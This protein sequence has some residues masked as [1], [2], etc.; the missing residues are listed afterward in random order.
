M[1]DAWSFRA[2]SEIDQRGAFESK[3]P[4]IE[5][6]VVRGSVWFGTPGVYLVKALVSQAL[7]DRGSVREAVSAYHDA[8]DVENLSHDLTIGHAGHL[9]GNAILLDALSLRPA[10]GLL[11]VCRLIFR[12]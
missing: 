10:R 8:C 9:L 12:T 3:A 7:G 1:A 11:M 2:V 4:G 5:G 6:S